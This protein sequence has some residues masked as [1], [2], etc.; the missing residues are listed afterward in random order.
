MSGILTLLYLTIAYVQGKAASMLGLLLGPTHPNCVV[1]FH[2]L[3]SLSLSVVYSGGISSNA[4]HRFVLTCPY[5]FPLCPPESSRH[6][7]NFQIAYFNVNG[8]NNFKHAELLLSLSSREVD[9]LVLI[10]ISL[11]SDSVF[12]LRREIRMELAQ[13]VAF[14]VTLPQ[15][16]D[17]GSSPENIKVGGDYNSQQSLGTSPSQFQIGSVQLMRRG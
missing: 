11:S 12:S 7:G 13:Q 17:L 8:L 2:P 9:C 6:V 5:A 15:R 10:A 1:P 16:L 14:L 3:I 4:L